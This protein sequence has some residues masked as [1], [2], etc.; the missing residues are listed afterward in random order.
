MSDLQFNKIFGA[1]LATGLVVVGL[2]VVS[3]AIFAPDLAEKPGYAIQVAETAE[4]GGEEAEAGPPDW[5]TVLPAA[6]V[7]MGATVSKKCVSCHV[8]EKGGANG[9]GPG[10][11]GVMGKPSGVH[12]GFAFSEAMVAHGKTTPWTFD[13]MYA[14]LK[15][16][17]KH[18]PGTKMSFVGLRKPE[19]RIN[20]I[21]YMNSMSDTPLPIPAPDPSRAPGAAAAAGPAVAAAGP[22]PTQDANSTSL[23]GTEGAVGVVQGSSDRQAAGGAAVGGGV[24]GQA[25]ASGVGAAPNA[26]RST[27]GGTGTGPTGQDGIRQSGQGGAQSTR[28]GQTSQ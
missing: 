13:E 5:G 7:A 28:G 12:P 17:Q 21:A 27:P 20:I 8:F 9:T 10:L 2:N 15:A 24:A 19:D 22:T 14:F 11:W 25:P 1:A 23:E 3:D 4:G 6:N 26:D 16:P 18:I